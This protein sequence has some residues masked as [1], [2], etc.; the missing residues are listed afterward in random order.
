MPL[1]PKKALAQ[2]FLEDEVVLGR[3]CRALGSLDKVLE[4]GAGQGSLTEALLKHGAKRLV[5]LEKDER[6]IP[7]LRRL[8]AECPKR[9]RIVRGDARR[10]K[11]LDSGL[12]PPFR[13]VGNLPYYIASNLI[14]GWLGQARAVAS[15][16]LLLQKEVAVRLTARVGAISGFSV[17]AQRVL[18]CELLFE[19]GAEHFSPPPQVT[20]ALVRLIPHETP[21]ASEAVDELNALLR[22][23]F[24]QRRKMLANSLKGLPRGLEALELQGVNPRGRAEEVPAEL[25]FQAAQA[26]AA[27]SGG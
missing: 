27:R 26:M 1:T 19:I 22:A 23:A 18:A 10:F 2:H 3:I 15:F 25:W 11:L 4:I 9:L 12:R 8:E 6:C 20:S 5:A 16:C 13:V 14:L 7:I 21:H 24:G 17:L